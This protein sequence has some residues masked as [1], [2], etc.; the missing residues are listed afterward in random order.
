MCIVYLKKLNLLKQKY[1]DKIPTAL[2]VFLFISNFSF[3]QN[4]QP[5]QSVK[6]QASA[7]S[8][9]AGAFIDVNAPGYPESSFTIDKLVKDVLISSGTNTCITLM[10]PM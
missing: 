9:K 3:S 4:Q 10:L 8:K 1:Y 6:K 2:F 5:R 7:Q